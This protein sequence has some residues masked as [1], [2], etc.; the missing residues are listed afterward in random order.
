MRFIIAA[1][2]LLAMFWVM[3]SDGYYHGIVE[4]RI[5]GVKP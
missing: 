4:R 5:A 2:A 3:S 1:I